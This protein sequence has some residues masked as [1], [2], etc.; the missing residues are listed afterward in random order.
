MYLKVPA[1]KAIGSPIKGTHENN[2]DH[3]PYFLKISEAFWNK[4]LFIGNQGFFIKKFIK[5]PNTQLIKEPKILPK[6]AKNNNKKTSY[7]SDSKSVTKYASE[8]NGKNVPKLRQKINS[9]K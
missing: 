5:Y 3:F 1:A 2:K 4:N 6:D 8:A 9:D 7:F